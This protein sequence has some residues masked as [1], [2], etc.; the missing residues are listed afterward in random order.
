[1]A[2]RLVSLVGSQA[3]PVRHI[4]FDGITFERSRPTFLGGPTSRRFMAS[5]SGD[6]SIYPSAAVYLSGS[7]NIVLSGCTL[8]EIGGNAVMMR[9]FNR[10][11]RVSSNEIHGCGDSAVVLLG[12]PRGGMISADVTDSN[13][14]QDVIV[15]KNHIHETGVLT[16]Q[17]SP[18]FLGISYHNNVTDNAMYN[19]PRAGIN[20]NDNAGG[21]S[22][23]TVSTHTR[24]L[25][26]ENT[27]Q[28]VP[29]FY[30]THS[31]THFFVPI[32]KKIKVAV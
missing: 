29:Q 3:A 24:S 20:F 17:S 28:N 9:G 5:G 8:R 25:L 6:W 26:Q 19:G 32:K 23:S 21:V 11:N 7:E 12:S 13:V 22:P 14:P 31:R 15:H 30:S 4:H 2:E 16:K 1:M 10:W 27:Q 18:I